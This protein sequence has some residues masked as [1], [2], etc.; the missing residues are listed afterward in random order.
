[1]CDVVLHQNYFYCYV[2]KDGLAVGAP[3]S[4]ILSEFYLQ[5][6]EHNSLFNILNGQ[7]F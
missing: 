5:Y 7:K 1:M 3:T 4:S 2:Q 6:L